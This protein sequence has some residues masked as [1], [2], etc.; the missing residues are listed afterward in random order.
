MVLSREYA[1][2]TCAFDPQDIFAHGREEGARMGQ[3]LVAARAMR[4]R[5]EHA[6]NR[7]M[8]LGCTA[9]ALVGG[10]ISG[11]QVR[12][13]RQTCPEGTV[14]YTAV[15]H[16]AGLSDAARAILEQ[17]GSGIAGSVNWVTQGE[18]DIQSMPDCVMPD[19]SADYIA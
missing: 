11:D 7:G 19:S 17:S 1:A 6:F 13:A 4:E 10:L 18:A 9:L 3:R 14:P 5:A 8:V 12:P 2:R 16:S 15:D